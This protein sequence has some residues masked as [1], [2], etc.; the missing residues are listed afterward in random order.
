MPCSGVVRPKGGP[1]PGLSDDDLD[2]TV[3]LPFFGE[4]PVT[5]EQVIERVLIGHAADHPNSLR[6]GL[7]R[8]ADHSHD[9]QE[10]LA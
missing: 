1:P 6:Q 5:A 10:A 9:R 8:T 4:N 7:E 3:I 2:R